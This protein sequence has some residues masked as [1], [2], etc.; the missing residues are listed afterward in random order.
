[1]DRAEVLIIG[2]GFA[3]ASVAWHLAERGVTN[4]AVLEREDLPGMHASSQNASMMRQFEEDSVIADCAFKGAGFIMTPPFQWSTIVEQVGSLI[5]FSKERSQRIEKA[6]E[7][8]KVRGLESRVISKKEAAARIPL[9]IDADFD[10]AFWTTTDG[11]VDINRYLWSYIKDFKKKRVKLKSG[12]AVLGIRRE[13][14][15]KF[16]VT[17]SEG[18]YL[19]SK[20][21][22]ATGA[23]AGEIGKMIGADDIPFQPF[24]R[25]L[26][27]TTEM[28]TVDPC[29]PFVWDVDRQYYFRPESGGLLLG[30][31]D[32]EEASPGLPST[33]HLIRE[34][35]ADKLGNYCPRL[36]NVRIATE[37]AGLRTFS[38]DRRFVLGEDP[39]VPGFY[40]AAG[41][42]GYGVTCSPE[43]GRLVAEAIIGNA[44]EIP[45]ELVAARFG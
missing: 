2:A 16:L 25:H 14:N 7:E 11:V 37:W 34:M 21:V 1:M 40:W 22:N 19:A 27:H 4:V 3:G 31:C 39:K 5:L 42:G 18:Y 26:Y 29:W 32:E 23:W 13:D 38:S 20:I 43:V 8:A 45:D 10:Q 9:L 28:E 24:R 6:M 41:L 17:T 15:G 33:S 35:L 36:A 44:S 12:Q 30:P